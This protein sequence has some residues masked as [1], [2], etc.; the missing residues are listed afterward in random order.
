MGTVHHH[1]NANA[2]QSGT[3]HGNEATIVGIHLTV[4]KLSE[5]TLDIHSRLSMKF[6]GEMADDGSV[7]RPGTQHFYESPDLTDWFQLPQPVLDLLPATSHG[8]I[9]NTLLKTPVGKEVGFPARWTENLIR[10]QSQ[11]TPAYN[12]QEHWQGSG[13]PQFGHRGGPPWHPTGGGGNRQFGA[14][15]DHQQPEGAQG[16]NGN[17]QSHQ[18]PSTENPAA[19]TGS[20]DDEWTY[21]NIIARM[22]PVLGGPAGDKVIG[23]DIELQTCY[24]DLEFASP[25]FA[26]L[27]LEKLGFAKTIEGTYCHNQELAEV[28]TAYAMIRERMAQSVLHH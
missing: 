15:W 2:F 4:G 21:A 13:H 10:F 3:D 5:P 18:V 28:N 1:C 19:L 17:G 8:V 27:A 14:K 23:H 24:A 9:L 25:H 20:S 26:G 7:I 12:Y 22:E 6:V 11:P 16:H